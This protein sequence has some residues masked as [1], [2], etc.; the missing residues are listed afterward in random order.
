MCKSSKWQTAG[1]TYIV[2]DKWLKLRADTCLTQEGKTIAPWYVLEY[3]EWVNCLVIDEDHNVVLL[4]HYRYAVNEFVTEIVAGVAE[5]DDTST[6]GSIRRELY[7]EL[8]YKGGELY[9]TG[10]AYANP[11]NHTN[12]VHMYLA[13]GGEASGQQ[14]EEVGA[15]YTIKKVPFHEFYKSVTTPDQK[16]IFQSLHMAA[17]FYS[18]N[19]IRSADVSNKS[20][21]QL[22]DL[23]SKP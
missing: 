3:P 22:R 6:I 23:I 15:E 16:E 4:N 5:E 11:S 2:N 13:V 1:S 17:I 18:L 7:E 10:V 12:K 21:D 14:H 20:L 8:G 9:K 19:F